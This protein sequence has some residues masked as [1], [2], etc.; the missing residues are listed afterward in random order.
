MLKYPYDD[1]YMTYDYNTHRYVLTLQ[2]VKQN[3]GI[4]LEN[5]TGATFANSIPTLLNKVSL[6]V[7]AFIHTHN[8]ANKYQDY[9]IAK[10]EDGRR[11]IR[12]AMEEQLTYLLT[13]GDVSRSLDVNERALAIDETTKQILLE[14]IREIGCSICYCGTLPIVNLGDNW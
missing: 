1:D 14:P 7:Y 2:D 13:V 4:D 8:V 11:I 12:E 10:T 6:K 3:L 9:I 5:R